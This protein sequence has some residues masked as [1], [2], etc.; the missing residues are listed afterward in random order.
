MY[1]Q[2][3]LELRAKQRA[4]MVI[5]VEAEEICKNPEVVDARAVF[6]RIQAAKLEWKAACAAVDM[7]SALSAVELEHASAA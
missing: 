2:A 1:T 7:E 6:D 3:Q 5:L 4:L